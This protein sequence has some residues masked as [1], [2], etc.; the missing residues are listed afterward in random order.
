MHPGHPQQD[1][2]IPHMAALQQQLAA[3]VSA[4]LA[5]GVMPSAQ[6]GMPG[7]LHQPPAA[8]HAAAGVPA[9]G[10]HEAKLPSP[11][12]RQDKAGGRTNSETYSF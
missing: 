4:G 9:Q 3:G 6:P 10:A 2:H 11:Q 5:A 8:P 12:R 7:V 1:P